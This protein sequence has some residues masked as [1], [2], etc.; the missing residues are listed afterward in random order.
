MIRWPD[1]LLTAAVLLWTFLA[2]CFPM[3][4][5]DFWWHL[6]T[7]ELI[8]ERGEVPQVDWYTYTDPDKPWIDLHWGFQ[9]LITGLYRFGGANLIVLAKAAIIT[10]AVGVAWS[11]GG[12][13]LPAWIKAGLW[14]LPI[15]AI[16]GRAYER[17]EILSQLFLACWLWIASRVEQRP[18][19]IWWLVPLQLVWVNC[20]ALFVLGLVI[21]ACYAVDRAIRFFA[22]GRWS[23]EKVPEQP[24]ERQL[25]WAAVCIAAVCF[26]NPYFEEGAFFPETLYRKFTVEQEFYSKNIGEFQRPIDFLL[27]GGLSQLPSRLKNIYVLAEFGTWLLTAVSFVALAV[28]GRWSVYRLLLF[29]AFTHLAWEAS[30]NT[31]I[32]AII[33]GTLLAANCGELWTLSRERAARW[34]RQVYSIAAGAAVLGLIVAVVSGQWNEWGEKNK[35]FGLGE[36]KVWFIH[37]A[38]KFAGQPGFPDRAFV[39]NNGQAAVFLYH[40]GPHRK[41]FMDA[42]LE[43]STME[44]FQAFNAVRDLMANAD[45]RWELIARRG[46]GEMPVVILDNRYSRLAIRGMAMQPGWRLVF[47]DDTAAVFLEAGRADALRLPQVDPQPLLQPSW[48]KSN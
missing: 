48:M 41:V 21:G 8:L 15:V 34:D 18:R 29:G 26:V 23:L 47:A 7:G 6:K 3:M 42:R 14:F 12:R 39:S 5:T 19:L 16:S 9:L 46:N 24:T 43:V 44:T 37:D 10:A 28:R 45:P 38:A 32:F 25:L 30:R 2:C 35:P 40:N 13:G 20:H 36:S 31:N 4:D 1:T 33:S 22:N 27:G 17:P 11:A